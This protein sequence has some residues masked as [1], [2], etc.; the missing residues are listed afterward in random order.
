M[1]YGKILID[2]LDKEDIQN[3]MMIIFDKKICS[4]NSFE[5]LKDLPDEKNEKDKEILEDFK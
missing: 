2:T 5:S 1:N 3:G 4:K